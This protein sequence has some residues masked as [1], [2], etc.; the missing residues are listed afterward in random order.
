MH[1]SFILCTFVGISRY[2][3]KANFTETKKGTWAYIQKAVRINGKST[4]IQVKKL[5]LLS[6]IQKEHGCQDPRQWVLDLARKMTLEEKAGHQSVEIP[7][8]PAKDIEPGHGSLRIGGDMFL[9]P[10]YTRLGL[11]VICENIKKRSRAKYNLDEILRTL[12][13]G[14]V[15]YPGSKHFTYAKSRSLVNPPE[16]A[17]EDMYRALS[18]LSGHINTIQAQVYKNSKAIMTRRDRI[19]YYDCTNYFFEIEDNDQDFIDRETG[20]FIAGLRKRGKS[21]ENRPNPIV[22]M[23][24]FMDMDG[25]PLAFVVFPGNE[26]EQA[27]LRPLEQILDSQFGMTEFIVSTDA[28]LG[29]ESNRRYNM[30]EG[31]DYICVQSL[32]SLTEDD[33]LAATDPRGWRLAYCC[34]EAHRHLLTDKYSD[35]GIFNLDYLHQCDEKGAG[36]RK[37]LLTGTTFYKEILVD[38]Y[39]KYENPEWVEA[40]KPNPETVP[41]YATGKRIPHYLKSV[42]KER[43]IVTYSHDF[44]M[45]LRHKRAER[46]AIAK[47]IVGRGLT[48][49]RRSQQSPLN[50]IE[51]IHSTE[52]GQTAVKTEMIIKDDVL[53][54]E[55]RL[56]GFYAYATSLDDE[57]LLVLRARSFHHEI[58]HLFRTTK[59]HL[60]VRPVYL[61][62]QDR[63]KSHFLICFLAMVILKMLQKQLME[64]YPQFYKDTPLTIDS[65]IDT[66]REIRFDKLPRHY[67]RPL[68]EP[69]EL[70]AQLQEM[71]G[72]DIN[73]EIISTQ[74]MK[75]TYKNLK[76]I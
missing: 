48:N 29:S 13:I 2:Y 34:D 54:Q 24:M 37:S 46:L 72:I 49:P 70:T 16:F 19:I 4:T 76:K 39:E 66:L 6:D 21:K 57:A 40:K 1:S 20:E 28:G 3:M 17:A 27:T 5:G 51:T 32:P 69:T 31:R 7:F 74:K 15:L 35:A 22:Q 68:F 73:K 65:L 26:S 47:K 42:R 71:Y 59:T 10:N 67:Y 63:I 64:E 18:L 58:E 36:G 61:S 55:E 41:K 14:R 8:C 62:R 43:L 30:A 12:V 45:Y 38:K 9:L 50:Y 25:I 23:G 75:A 11:P 44:A 60:D 52:D 33:R 53:Q 56:D